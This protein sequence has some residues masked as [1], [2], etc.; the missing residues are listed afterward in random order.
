MPLT[1]YISEKCSTAELQFTSNLHPP[2]HNAN[3]SLANL[4]NNGMTICK[5]LPVSAHTEIL[6]ICQM[7]SVYR[8]H[9]PVVV[10]KFFN[11]KGCVACLFD[12]NDGLAR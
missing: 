6:V 3:R 1:G 4:S 8:N 12:G 10:M 9:H 2:S 11:Q 5:Y 7:P